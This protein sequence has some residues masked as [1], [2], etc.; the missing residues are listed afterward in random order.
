[1]SAQSK[2]KTVHAHQNQ[3][4]EIIDPGEPSLPISM[5]LRCTL[6]AP[7]SQA[8]LW[9]VFGQLTRGLGL[10]VLAQVYPMSLLSGKQ[11][12]AGKVPDDD[13][14]MSVRLPSSKL[15]NH[16]KNSARMITPPKRLKSTK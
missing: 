2:Q 1:M 6:I 9:A 3:N 8:R 5:L 10:D 13:T 11:R 12:S 15:A 16:L 14:V 4:V 7:C